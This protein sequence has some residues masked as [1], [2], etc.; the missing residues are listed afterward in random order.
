MYVSGDRVGLP[1]RCMGSTSKSLISKWTQT[2]GMEE[3]GGIF[4]LCCNSS[5]LPSIQ[6][7]SA[8]F[9]QCCFPLHRFNKW[10]ATEKESIQHK[11]KAIVLKNIATY[12][13]GKICT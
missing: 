6:I 9:E 11:G 5:N 4:I 8:C 12:R 2:E 1:H 3:K 10:R 13:L 7:D